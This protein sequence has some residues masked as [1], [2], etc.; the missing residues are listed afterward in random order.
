MR[1]VLDNYAQLK[2]RCVPVRP[3]A[4]LIGEEIREAKCALRRANELA[5]RSKLTVR[6]ELFVKQRNLLKGLH[7]SARKEHYCNKLTDCTS[8]KLFLWCNL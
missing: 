5:N 8:A 4:P 3:S 2:T 6:R 1:P 7:R